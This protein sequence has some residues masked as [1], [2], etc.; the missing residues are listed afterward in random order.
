MIS[1]TKADQALLVFSTGNKLL[2]N[3]CAIQYWLLG[4]STGGGQTDSKWFITGWSGTL[5]RYT[6][7]RNESPILWYSRFETLTVAPGLLVG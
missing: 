3:T 4:S 5:V 1:L 7:V 6:V 2:S